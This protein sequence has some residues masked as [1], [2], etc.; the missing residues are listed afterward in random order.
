M[1][2]I[3]VILAIGLVLA[4]TIVIAAKAL[5][6]TEKKSEEENKKDFMSE[7]EDVAKKNEEIAAKNREIEKLN[8]RKY[9][10]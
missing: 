9:H 2:R 3:V 6:L 7:I 4:F 5:G 10:L 8:S 1:I